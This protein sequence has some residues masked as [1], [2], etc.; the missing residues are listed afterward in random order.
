MGA[1]GA[2]L[3]VVS[4][5]SWNRTDAP[6]GAT[7]E[8]HIETTTAL[9]DPGPVTALTALFDD[10]LP[11]AAAGDP[12]PP[13][14]HWV[15]LPHWA[16][17]GQLGPDGHPRRGGF[18]PPIALP[19]RMFAGGQVRFH[20]P[21]MVGE[22]VRRETEVLSVSPKT[23]RSGALVIVDVRTRLFGGSGG[24][25]VE[26]VQNLVYREAAPPPHGDPPEAPAATD[27]GVPLHQVS[28]TEWNLR[29]DPTL[30]MRF[31][32]A[33]AN[34]HRIHYDWPYAT[35]VEGYPGLVVHGPL[36]ALAL[37]E[38]HRLAAGAPV[39]EVHHR[40]RAPLFCGDPARIRATPRESGVLLELFGPRGYS[41][42]PTAT[43]DVT[44]G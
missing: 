33:T 3:F 21:L 27:P 35:A 42:E 38:T 6:L 5:E 8:P 40:G 32:A 22:T 7:W 41:A 14:W 23:G 1:C 13:L 11:A 28:A 12:L 36:Q 34:A 37:A 24:L 25:A 26:E 44:T 39:V 18:L 2:T 30:L 43:L 4:E 31:S 17:S 16:A 10:G 15:A 19:R 20:A 9:V 29:T